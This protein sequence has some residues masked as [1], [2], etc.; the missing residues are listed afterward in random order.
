M[1][2]QMDTISLEKVVVGLFFTGVKLSNG[3]GGFCFTPVDSKSEAI[4][5]PREGRMMP[6]AG[7]FQGMPVKATLE[8]M[9]NKNLFNKAL[10][11]AAINALSGIVWSN[12]GLQ[13]YRLV[14]NPATKDTVRIKEGAEVV[15]VGTLIPYMK[16]LKARQMPFCVLEKDT[17]ALKDDELPFYA[18]LDKAPE[19]IP[20]ADVLI[21]TGTALLDD[22]LEELL[23]LAK[24]GAEIL[25][26]GPTGSML[27]EALLKRG[28]NRINGVVVTKPDELLDTL[29]AG[30]SGLHL[31]GKSAEKILI[32]KN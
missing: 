30:G 9:F 2:D 19:K 12:G 27:P 15:V 17:S 32:E 3:C 7:R 28:V 18:P 6:Y 10:G 23:A 26:V 4:C 5:C 13:G 29:A 25:L 11:L 21:V 8:E 20:H 31:F 22:T 24:P 14:Q 1:G 16:L